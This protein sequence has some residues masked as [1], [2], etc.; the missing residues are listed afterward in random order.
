MGIPIA[1]GTAAIFAVTAT[2][3]VWLLCDRDQVSSPSHSRYS[4]TRKKGFARVTFQVWLTS[5]IKITTCN[6]RMGQKPSNDAN[7]IATLSQY[8]DSDLRD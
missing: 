2:K 7:I 4:D 8:K 5:L 1:A 3:V 6:F